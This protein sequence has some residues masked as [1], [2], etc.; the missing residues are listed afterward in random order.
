MRM[1]G[2]D[3]GRPGTARKGM[4]L[5]RRRGTLRRMPVTLVGVMGRLHHGHER[6]WVV[7]Q[8]RILRRWMH[9]RVWGMQAWM[10]RSVRVLRHSDARLRGHRVLPIKRNALTVRR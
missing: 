10:V 2:V 8:K 6:V 5:A 7:S 4:A 9:G 3:S 1:R